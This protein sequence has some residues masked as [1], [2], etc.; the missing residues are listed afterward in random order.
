MSDSVAAGGEDDLSG[1]AV[2]QARHLLAGAL[3]GGAGVLP[4]AV[5][6]ARVRE[7]LKQEGTHG[8]EDLRQER[9]GGVGVEIDGSSH[10][11]SLRR[12]L[13]C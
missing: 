5:C 2:Q 11:L 9:R 7:G 13:N 3:H 8:V 10:G 4:L 1:A 6:G 12:P